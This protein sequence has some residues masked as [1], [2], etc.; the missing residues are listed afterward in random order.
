[1]FVQNLMEFLINVYSRK[2]A[3]SGVTKGIEQCMSF[4]FND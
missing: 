4:L 3:S 1:M 2:N